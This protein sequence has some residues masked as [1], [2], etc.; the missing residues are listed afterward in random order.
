MLP[1]GVSNLVVASGKS[2][3]TQPRGLI[4]GQVSCYVLGQGAGAAAATAVSA[5]LPAADVNLVD[6]QRELLRQNVYLGEPSRLQE[7]GLPG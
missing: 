4:R 3:S 7:L 1:Q 2:V 6:V 5:G